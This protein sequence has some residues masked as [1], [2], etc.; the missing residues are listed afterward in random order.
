M[1][2][3]HVS[4]KRK[5]R[6]PRSAGN[7]NRHT[8]VCI[9]DMP[10][11]CGVTNF[12][13]SDVAL[14]LAPTPA[15]AAALAGY[16][17]RNGN[18]LC[19]QLHFYGNLRHRD[20]LTPRSR[21]ILRPAQRCSRRARSAGATGKVPGTTTL[22]APCDRREGYPRPHPT[23]PQHRSTVTDATATR[24]REAK[25]SWSTERW[26]QKPPYSCLHNRFASQLRR[27]QLGAPR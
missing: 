12:A 5:P 4:A 14:I 11:S 27:R 25:T 26:E 23:N 24:V 13:R 15:A 19:R 16:G 7:K 22:R 6:G 1:R 8:S 18:A 9:T 21:R 3:R 20:P 17:A 10:V 2:G